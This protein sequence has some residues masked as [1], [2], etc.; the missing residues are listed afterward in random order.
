MCSFMNVCPWSAC[1]WQFFV[2]HDFYSYT[3][4][5]KKM[6]ITSSQKILFY[7]NIYVFGTLILDGVRLGKGKGEF[8]FINLKLK[9]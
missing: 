5:K 9:S 6:W 4:V 3:F 1:S 2:L 7:K 8:N